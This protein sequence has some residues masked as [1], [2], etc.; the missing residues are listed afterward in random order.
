MAGLARTDLLTNAGAG[1]GAA[2]MLPVPGW[3]QFYVE[4]TGFGSIKLQFQSPQNTFI[5]VPGS[6][7][8]ANGMVPLQLPAGQYRAVVTGASAAFASLLPIPT[9][10]TR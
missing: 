5:D 1:N 3:Y 7:Q 10:T 9:V 2:V 6:S 4:G 8:T